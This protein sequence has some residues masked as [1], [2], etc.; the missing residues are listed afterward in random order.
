MPLQ[1]Y[2]D[3]GSPI[4]ITGPFAGLDTR[5][6]PREL[7]PRHATRAHN[8]LLHTGTIRPRPPFEEDARFTAFPPGKVYAGV[9]W[10]PPRIAPAQRNLVTVL[11]VGDQLFT[12]LGGGISPVQRRQGS[13]AFA[14]GNLYYMDGLRV[15]R[16]DGDQWAIAG[17]PPPAVTGPSI[18][19]DQLATLDPGVMPPNQIL[20]GVATG[21]PSTTSPPAALAWGTTYQFAWTWY[22]QVHDCE[23]N[24]YFTL[25]FT[26]PNNTDTNHVAYLL[27]RW[28]TPPPQRGVTHVRAYVRNVTA[29]ESFYRLWTQQSVNQSPP[30]DFT[31]PLLG[32]VDTGP[33]VPYLNSV[34]EYAS[35]GWFYKN[36]MFYNDLR[37]PTR[38]RY[39]A[40]GR[41]EHV[42]MDND[43]EVADDDGGQFCGMGV[44][45]GQLVCA[46]ERSIWILSGVV[47]APTNASV[48]AGVP[49]SSIASTHEFYQTKAKTGC[50]NAA[51]GNGLILL[52]NRMHYNAIDGFYRF[53]GVEE[54]RVSSLIDPTWKQFVGDQ[55]FGRFQ[56]VSYGHD[57]QRQIL[58]LVNLSVDT[59]RV[60]ILAYH[61]RLNGGA[62]AWTTIGP[63]DPAD[64]PTCIISLI[65]TQDP[66]APPLPG[67]LGSELRPS[68]LVIAVGDTVRILAIND[69]RT[70]LPLPPIEY[71]TG[72]LVVKEGME[73]HFYWVKWLVSVLR[74]I[75]GERTLE[76]GFRLQPEN[77]DIYQTFDMTAATWVRQRIEGYGQSLTLLVRTPQNGTSLWHPDMSI[78]GFGL[79]AEPV[80]Q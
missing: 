55:T 15:Y 1:D 56:A 29:G 7:S 28:G 34:P 52:D 70:D 26:T 8:V 33:F 45:A 58:Y 50:A 43:F 66:A 32:S 14:A 64:N 35:V 2:R 25:E 44:Q 71:A 27:Y 79:D 5:H 9:D 20:W 19:P 18:N 65:G 12:T 72:E 49:R 48:N 31:G 22:D 69:V 11:H 75:T 54:E 47:L 13:F 4:T 40:D 30:Y 36:R 61:Y 6:E 62:G 46:K 3:P 38:L 51:G 68:N 63:D 21:I 67:G 16:Y 23:S 41:P 74:N 77:D 10:Y 57:T 60:P 76:M 59:D 24:G 42:D 78:T 39:S 80:G 73:A 37:Y 53:N 17:I